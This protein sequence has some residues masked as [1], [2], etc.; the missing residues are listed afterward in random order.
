MI[1]LDREDNLDFQ[2]ELGWLLVNY[3]EWLGDYTR[4]MLCRMLFE[5]LA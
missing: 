5:A 2:C 4:E 3:G 1:D